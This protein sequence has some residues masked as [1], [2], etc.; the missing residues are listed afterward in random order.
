MLR[1]HL[2][3]GEPHGGRR[4]LLVLRAL[5]G[6]DGGGPA[7][8]GRLAAHL[9]GQFGLALYLG[10]VLLDLLRAEAADLFASELKIRKY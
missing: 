1:A 3:V 9:V 4:L 5:G 2:L 7:V 10:K 8:L 6:G